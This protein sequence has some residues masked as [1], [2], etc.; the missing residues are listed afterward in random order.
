MLKR[1]P[2]YIDP[3]R[4]A[5]AGG[6]IVGQIDIA[7]MSRLA[8]MLQNTDA[9]VELKLDFGVDAQGVRCVRGQL[10]SSF[11]MICQRC[12]EPMRIPVEVKV[13]LGIVSTEAEAE[14]LP[15]C[16]EPLFTTADPSLL[17]NLIE[18]ELLLALPSAPRHGESECEARS[19][20]QE[21][22]AESEQEASTGA[23]SPFAVLASLKSRQ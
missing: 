6:Q 4:L 20:V 23:A 1:V 14:R 10:S 16:Y 12:L 21:Q 18:D 15:E 2:Q 19:A 8:P 3:R 17:V 22:A 5:D 13:S 9:V 11:T 7:H